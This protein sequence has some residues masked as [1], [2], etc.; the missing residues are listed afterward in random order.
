MM[1]TAEKGEIVRVI[2]ARIMIK[3][4]DI[5]RGGELKPADDAALERIGILRNAASLG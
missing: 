2:I 4:G 5:K 3:V 1:R